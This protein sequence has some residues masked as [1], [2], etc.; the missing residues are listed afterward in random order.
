MLL[1]SEMHC[2]LHYYTARPKIEGSGQTVDAVKTVLSYVC[3][4]HI[5]ARSAAATVG[6]VGFNITPRTSGSCP[7]ITSLY[8]ASMQ[9]AFC[10]AWLSAYAAM[11]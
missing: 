6:R 3:L 10:R 9:R 7:S 8:E 1:L 4:V 5:V 11:G 2:S